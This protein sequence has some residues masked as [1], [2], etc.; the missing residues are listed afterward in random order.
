[1]ADLLWVVS[2]R[3]IS[4]AV[5]VGSVASAATTGAL[6]AIGHRVGSIG[7]PFASIG[8]VLLRQS[9]TTTAALMVVTGLVLHI[10]V[11]WLWSLI[12]VQLARAITTRAVAAGVIAAGVVAAGQ[13]TLSWIIAWSS[14]SGLASVLALGDRIVYAVVLAG[15]MVVGMRFAFPPRETHDRFFV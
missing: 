2:A 13:F 1:V 6:I 11:T 12:G 4:P 14:G 9:V 3:P 8:A 7:L 5:V 10:A 15:A